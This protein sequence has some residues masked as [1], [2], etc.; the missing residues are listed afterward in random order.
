[1]SFSTAN[2][3]KFILISFCITLQQP[4][5]HMFIFFQKHIQNFFEVC[6]TRNILIN[7]VWYERNTSATAANLTKYNHTLIYKPLDSCGCCHGNCI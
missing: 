4:D 3:T 2:D 6:E 5:Q 7:F 1:M